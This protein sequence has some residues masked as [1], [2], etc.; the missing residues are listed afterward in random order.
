MCVYSFEEIAERVRPVAEKYGL[1]SVYLFGSYARGDADDESDVDLLI[2]DGGVHGAFWLGGLY[3]D[4]CEALEKEVDMVTMDS[5][6]RRR[7]TKYG[8][9]FVE[10]VEL[11]RRRIV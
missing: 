10:E 9:R 6:E 11:D 2:D 7:E 4:F 8:K 5:L 3:G 1:K